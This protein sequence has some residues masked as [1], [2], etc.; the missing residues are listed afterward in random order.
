VWEGLINMV[1]EIPRMTTAK[2]EVAT[3]VAHNPIVQDVKK[4]KPRHYAGPIFW[5]YGC[6]PQ[7]WCVMLQLRG[8]F[9]SVMVARLEI[10]LHAANGLCVLC[11]TRTVWV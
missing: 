4:G 5:N 8:R 9:V 2:Y 11:T 1:V 7:V 6:A 3:G 10:R